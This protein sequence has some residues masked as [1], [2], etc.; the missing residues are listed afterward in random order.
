MRVCLNFICKNEAKIIRRMLDSVRGVIDCVV[1]VDTGSDDGTVPLIES[2]CIENGKSRDVHRIQFE[3]FEQARNEA[4]RLCR[5]SD[6]KFDYILLLDADF[7]GVGKL[8]ELTAQAYSLTIKGGGISYRR[9]QLIH[10]RLDAKYIGVTHEYLSLPVQAVNLDGFH[11]EDLG[12]GGGKSDKYERDIRLLR[13]DLQKNPG[14]SRSMYYLAESYRNSGHFPDAA[15]WYG[16]RTQAGGW[17]EEAWH[18]A[19]MK[20]V[21]ERELKNEAAFVRDCW[22][23]Y[24]MRPWRSEPLYHL[25]K[26]WREQG[27]NEQAMAVCEIGRDITYPHADTLFVEDWIYEWGWLEE[28][29]I[30]GFYCR[31]KRRFEAGAKACSYKCGA[32][33]CEAHGAERQPPDCPPQMDEYLRDTA[34]PEPGWVRDPLFGVSTEDGE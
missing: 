2:W 5:E 12:D 34:A 11:V 33:L 8:P 20:A 14:N 10:R 7:I 4:L 31:D 28:Q 13:E 17:D 9:P 3:N 29:S 6:L 21:C 30:V 24:G 23:A 16:Q 19:Y 32:V 25:A 15:L 26:Y 22:T 27:R 18:A 1:A